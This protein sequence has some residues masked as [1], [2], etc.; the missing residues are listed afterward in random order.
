LDSAIEHLRNFLTIALAAHGLALV[1]CNMT[2]TPKDD[3]FISKFYK[4]IEVMAG[5]ITPRAK[6]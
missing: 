6:K 1:I 5:I 4:L 2:K 3:E